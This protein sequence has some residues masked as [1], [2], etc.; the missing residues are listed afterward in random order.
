M[1]QII[2]DRSSTGLQQLAIVAQK[3]N[4]CCAPM[5]QR[6]C[7]LYRIEVAQAFS[8]ALGPHMGQKTTERTGIYLYTFFTNLFSECARASSYLNL[9]LDTPNNVWHPVEHSQNAHT[10]SIH[11]KLGC[12]L[13]NYQTQQP[14]RMIST[15][16][17][18][19]QNDSNAVTPFLIVYMFQTHSCPRY[20]LMC[21]RYLIELSLSFPESQLYLVE[22]ISQHVNQAT[23]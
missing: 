21:G 17:H 9:Y 3:V 1:L 18:C 2:D 15:C 20:P 7:N 10:F 22:L 4:R 23:T 12:C 6:Y 19:I 13:Q 11:V 16:A 5:L 8:C 14:P